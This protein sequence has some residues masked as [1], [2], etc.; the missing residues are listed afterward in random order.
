MTGSQPWPVI[1]FDGIDPK[2]SI[3]TVASDFRQLME[4]MAATDADN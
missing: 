1:K 3:E 2:G 4:L